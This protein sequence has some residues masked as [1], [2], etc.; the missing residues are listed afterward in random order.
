MLLWAPLTVTRY[1]GRE[2]V[3]YSGEG[4]DKIRIGWNGMTL[5]RGCIWGCLQLEEGRGGRG[6][7]SQEG[8][9]ML[10]GD[11]KRTCSSGLPKHSWPGG[12]DSGRC[13]ATEAIAH[14]LF[15]H[16]QH[17]SASANVEIAIYPICLHGNIS[18][19]TYLHISMVI[20]IICIQRIV[21]HFATSH[22][23]GG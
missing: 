4:E 10:R 9:R 15:P 18:M 22:C 19:A 20:C 1:A 21:A 5:A 8:V 2:P 6:R 13:L 7:R 16:A 3:Q 17:L 23:L 14:S 12:G 11:I